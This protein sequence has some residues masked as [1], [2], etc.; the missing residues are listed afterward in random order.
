M[1]DPSSLKIIAIIQARMGSSRLPDKVML[2]IHGKPMLVRVI[3]RA[4]Q[5]KSLSAVAVATTSD[6]AEEPIAQLCAHLHAPCARGSVYDVLDRYH[7]TA[8]EFGAEVVVRLTADCPLLDPG[9]IDDAVAAFLDNPTTCGTWTSVYP[10]APVLAP[11]RPEIPWDFA[12][13][14]LPPPFHRTYPIGLDVEICTFEALDRAWREARE[15]H[16]REHVMPYLY[17]TPGRFRCRIGNYGT[18]FGGQRWTVDTPEDLEVVR[19]VY[20]A[21]DGREDFTWLDVLH[22]FEGHPELSEINA[23]I[24]HKTFYDVDSRRGGR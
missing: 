13:N 11:T 8:V 16:E 17:E 2:D 21:F 10:D 22:L 7:Q 9:L 15:P 18:D 1:I 23:G 20:D 4:R 5:A 6:P 24:S 3:E 14:R 19:K 12:A